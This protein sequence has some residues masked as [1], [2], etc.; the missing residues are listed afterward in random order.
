MPQA[1]APPPARTAAAPAAAASMRGAER[2][3]GVL[4]ALNRNNGATVSQ[5]AAATGISRP[6]LYRVLESLCVQGYVSRRVD[7]DTYELTPLVRSLSDGFQ[8][9]DWVRTVAT[10]VI[11]ELQEQ[12]VW[13]TDLST[14]HG[15]AMYLRE[16]TR[17]NSP[18][19][20]DRVT[21]GLRLPMLRSA[22][23]KAYL[24]WCPAKEQ[25][26]ILSNLR[27][28]GHRD[29]AGAH[30][31]K[32]VASL[33][34]STR[35]RGY[36]ERQEEFAERTGAIAIPVQDGERVIAC[37]SIT[38]IASA[39]TPQQAARRHLEQMRAAVA[40][41]QEGLKLRTRSPAS[42]AASRSAAVGS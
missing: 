38:F 25:A 4:A 18:M 20:I 29:D 7:R 8:D 17:S 12:V 14:F 35:R 27:A 23:G 42:P 26:L 22:S 41:I 37:L 3:L 6:A 40:R 16:T 15:N 2:T 33:I 10:P 9:E 5:L 28:T 30:D 19:T 39:L 24:A 32:W 36:G 34:A 21:V 1:P 11:K 13:P 31:P